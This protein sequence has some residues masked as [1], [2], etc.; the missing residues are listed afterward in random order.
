MPRRS[1]RAPGAPL[2]RRTQT[3]VATA[4][5]ALAL[6][7]G[8]G[9]ASAGTGRC[10]SGVSAEGGLSAYTAILAV[11]RM[12]CRGALRVALTSPTPSGDDIFEPGNRWRLGRWRCRTLRQDGEES[13]VARCSR[14][15]RAFTVAWGA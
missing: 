5:C 6:L 14:R 12:T 15:G 13:W 9:S 1:I 4:V 8:T 11:K 7:A 10:P 2:S 3:A